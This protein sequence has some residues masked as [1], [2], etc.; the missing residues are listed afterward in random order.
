MYDLWVETEINKDSFGELMNEYSD[1]AAL[2]R[3][4]IRHYLKYAERTDD[5]TPVAVEL[6]LGA[7]FFLADEMQSYTNFSEKGFKYEGR[8]D[9]IV[10]KRDGSLWVLEHKTARS[11]EDLDKLI[12][13]EQCTSYIMLAR[14]N[15]YPVQG[16]IY[17]VLKKKI[18]I[19]PNV[20]KNGQRLYAIKLTATTYDLYMG[21]IKNNG[22][23]TKDYTE[24]LNDL[25]TMSNSFFRRQVVTRNDYELRDWMERLTLEA[26]DMTEN[27]RIYPTFNMWCKSCSFYPLC[28][29]M[30]DGS[31]VDWILNTM[32]KKKQ[33]E[34]KVEAP[35]EVW[36]E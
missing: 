21:A 1:E 20:T 23:D 15:G 26:Q 22:F 16:V 4:M 29:A 9:G 18:P 14:A 32:Y 8:I 3:G 25:A 6:E 17:N 36:S 30:T 31:D 7:N 13:D 2:G 35:E 12:L 33:K 5:F 34:E 24:Q 11:F 10:K 27:P 19:V 28:V